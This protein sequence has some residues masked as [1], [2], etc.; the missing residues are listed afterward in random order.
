[1]SD[2]LIKRLRSPSISTMTIKRRT[3]L[4]NEA[5]DVLEVKDAEME[6]LK[7]SAGDE[8]YQANKR[9]V[10]YGAVIKAAR[11]QERMHGACT[12]LREALAALDGEK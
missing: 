2:D 9:L 6:Q 8:Q 11:F 12:E 4:L 5:V 10:G 1:M 7:K 3:Q